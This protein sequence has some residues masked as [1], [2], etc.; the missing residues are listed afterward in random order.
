MKTIYTLLVLF[1]VSFGLRLSAQDFSLANGRIPVTSLDGQWRF[2]PGDSP[3]TGGQ[4]NGQAG[5]H[6]AWADPKFEDSKWDLISSTH[7]WD[8]H[9]YPQAMGWYRFRVAVSAG[10]DP[11]T[12]DLPQ[13]DTCYQVF[14][15][16]KLIGS[17]G[18]M[19][20][21]PI[22]Y[23]GGFNHL[24]AVPLQGGARTITFAIRVW[25]WPALG[26]YYGGG[27]LYFG[28][29]IGRTA[30]VQAL[31]SQLRDSR[32]WIFNST[33]IL[34]L[35]ETLA[36]L[37]ALALFLLRTSDRE[38]LGFCLVLFS[39]A[40]VNWLTLSYFFSAWPMVL[41]DQ[42]EALLLGPCVSLAEIAF[43][44]YLLKGKRTRL[45]WLAV[46]SSLFSVVYSL[47][48]G[49]LALSPIASYLGEYLLMLPVSV[50]ILSLLFIRARHNYLDARLLAAPV[51]LQKACLI[52]QQLSIITSTLGWQHTFE[53]RVRITDTPFRIEVTQVVDLLFLL[54]VLTILILRFSRTR[55]HEELYARDVEGARSVQQFLIPRQLPEVVGLKFESEYRPAREVG[56]DF[57]QV[58]PDYLDG[59]ALI[60]IGDVAGKGLQAGMLATLIVGAL[61]TATTFSTDPIQILHT[62]NNRLCDRGN[63][64]CLALRI[65]SEGHATLVNAGH[66]PPYLNG[67]E[68][69]IEGSLP[70][71][72]V[73]GIEFPI[74]EFK[75]A[76]GDT[77]VLMSDGVAEAQDAHG[78]LFGFDRIGAMLEGQASAAS[79]ADAA[80]KF[81][82]TDDI[83]VLA[84]TRFAQAIQT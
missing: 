41:H 66:L 3:Q 73:P 38:Y 64:T 43:Y 69:T 45:F 27:P 72:I 62:L 40:A 28:S 34:A 59:S 16:G 11:L 78:G 49:T 30:E 2:H 65:S 8:S 82:Q 61:R 79:V 13:I 84:I 48:S 81:G 14:A 67:K 29:M 7:V 80:Q 57:F 9:V 25:Q 24:Y 10:A 6:W 37:A 21:N 68:L 52:F 18:K 63:A 75:L 15:D 26:R 4:D 50:W 20:P 31:D 70:L 32:H 23:W 74:F 36:A 46:V 51:V 47:L 17:Y 22:P 58:I 71:G 77:L 56:G 33:L 12:L 54:G 83:T 53:Y 5:K 19:P 35:L 44:F 76:T 39:A 55:S 60:V 1:L 42:L